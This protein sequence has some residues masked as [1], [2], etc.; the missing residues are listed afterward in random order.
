MFYS[1]RYVL[2]LTLQQKCTLQYSRFTQFSN[3]HHLMR[4]YVLYRTDH[5]HKNKQTRTRDVQNSV[6]A[7]LYD[8]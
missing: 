7:C 1:V 8:K 5:K 2:E 3:R 4:S 6:F